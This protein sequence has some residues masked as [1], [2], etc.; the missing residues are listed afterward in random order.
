MIF[1]YEDF[2]TEKLEQLILESAI[3]Y[4]DK[5][6]TALRRM[7]GDVVAKQLLDLE[8]VDLD[9][10]ANFFDINPDNDAVVTF[11][12]D[13]VAR[14][15]LDEG[16]EKIIVKLTGSKGG[17]LSNNPRANGAIFN[18]LG[19][20]PPDPK[21]K[22]NKDG[23]EVI[24]WSPVYDPGNEVGVI[25]KAVQSAKTGKTW[26]YTKFP[27]GEGVYSRDKLTDVPAADRRKEV[28]TKGRQEVRIGRAMRLLLLSNGVKIPDQEIEVFVNGFRAIIAVMNNAF[29]RF[30]IVEGDDLGFWYNEKNYED[31]RGSLGS[32]CQA[33][34]RLDWLEIYIKNP[35]TVQLVILR[36]EKNWDK[37]TGRALLWKLTGDAGYMMDFTYV[38][39]DQDAKLFREFAAFSNWKMFD[40]VLFPHET[41]VADIKPIEFK[42]Y[43]SVDTM[44]N[45]SPKNG[46]IS[47]R[48]FT[49]SKRI[50]W[51]H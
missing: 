46:K 17:W 22:N 41:F 29:S 40:S 12:P 44:N 25:V 39:R 32:S 20:T 38:I 1:K 31:R 24:E 51:T 16:K 18:L 48:A 45:W 28:F 35:D 27:K 47:N 49:G 34:G 19:Y 30:D 42:A 3:V 50:N 33:V 6:K 21:V 14:Q 37:I 13:R 2:L 15:V 10:V 4:S 43:P 26:C 36:S 7:K 9:V 5:F 11:T 8:N 23:T